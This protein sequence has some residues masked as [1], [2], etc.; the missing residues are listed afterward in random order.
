MGIFDY[1]CAIAG[2]KCLLNGSNGQDCTSGTVYLV[3]EG[4]TKK[5]KCNYSGYAYAC[6]NDVKIY[7][8]GHQEFFEDWDVTSLNKV[9]LIACS[10]C[11]KKIKLVIMRA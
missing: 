3:D 10:Q 6:H 8:L 1:C 4:L 5:L 11:S 2:K 9:S 7:D